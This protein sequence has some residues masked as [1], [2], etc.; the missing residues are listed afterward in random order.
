[1]QWNGAD[2]Y[3]VSDDRNLVDV[4]LVHAWLSKESYWATGRPIE[5]VRR[6][7]DGSVTLGCYASNGEQVAVC[8]WVT[9]SATFAWLCDVFVDSDERGKGLG[10]FLVESAMAHPAVQGLRLLLLGTRDAQGLYSRFGFAPSAGN[11]ME[12]RS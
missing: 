9:D 12:V 5:V 1:M 11:W 4:D 8:R 10:V 6:S 2:G 3:F 7:I